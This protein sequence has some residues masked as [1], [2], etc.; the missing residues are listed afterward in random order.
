MC[1]RCLRPVYSYPFTYRVYTLESERP[2]L[3]K[4]KQSVWNI[5]CKATT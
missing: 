2:A 3:L 5:A 4:R 1:E